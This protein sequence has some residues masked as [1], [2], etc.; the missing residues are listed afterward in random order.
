MNRIA[1]IIPY[2]GQFKPSIVLF[3]ESC[4]RNPE[5]D[6]LVFTDNPVPD[7][8]SLNTNVK[9]NI[10]SLEGIH[11]LACQKLDMQIALERAYKLCDLKPFYGLIFEDYLKQYSHWGYGDT[12][13]IYGRIAPFMRKINYTQY[14]KINWM[15][16]LCILKNNTECRMAALH[17]CDGTVQADMILA[18][19]SNRGFDERDYNIKCINKGLKI[20][21]EKWAADIDIFYWRMRCVDIKTLHL[22]LDTKSIEYAPKNYRK[23]VFALIEG[24]VYRIYIKR[25]TVQFEEFAYIHFRKE[26]PI[27]FDDVTR[28]TFIIS[29]DGFYPVDK[30]NL[31]N[32]NIVLKVINKYNDQENT[33]QEFRSFLHQYYRKASGKRGW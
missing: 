23:Q 27:E 28:D 8:I 24:K 12:D 7:R 15:G 19:P 3:L 26:V 1:V 31:G 17:T 13:V 30:D 2:F 11:E 20:Y 29:R 14:D 16:H 25:N 5:I 32:L 22:L 18:D 21:N 6:W 10:T 4:N 33:T 9:W